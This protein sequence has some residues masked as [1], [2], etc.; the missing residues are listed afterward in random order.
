[1]NQGKDNRKSLESVILTVI[2]SVFFVF[3]IYYFE[4][5]LFL[6]PI[7]FIAFGIKND[8]VTSLLDF[9]ITLL[10]VGI[11][12]N[13]QVSLS[14]F[15]LFAPF[16]ALS[17]Y[18]IKKRTRA[19]QVVIYGAIALFIS[20]LVLFGISNLNGV[21]LVSQLEEQFSMILSGRM[22]YLKDMGLTT[23]ELLETRDS[24]KAEYGQMLTLIP[25]VI[26]IM[27]Y[28]ISYI[29]YK[30]VALGLIKVG[31]GVLY[32]PRF[33][34]FRL[35]DNF[36]IGALI[37][38]LT[39]FFITMMNVSYA[40]VLY[41]N[42]IVLLGSVIALQGLAIVSFFLNKIKMKKFLRVITYIIIFFTPQ[43]FSAMALLGGIDIIFD[44]RKIKGAKSA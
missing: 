42:I 6:L 7:P 43:I 20:M 17:I 27:S 33:S 11:M 12:L 23:Y 14:Y 30:L 21:N 15:L 3:S 32:L 13:P 37:M 44:L 41:V 16:I 40:D 8:L 22:D 10:I 4:A 5:L 38:V 29:N 18:L 36:T 35:P 19:N 2:M 25:S 26:L 1:M 31:I 24:L 34:R 39:S 9:V 28:I